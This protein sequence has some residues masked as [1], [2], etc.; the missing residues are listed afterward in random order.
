VLGF[1]LQNSI[2]LLPLQLLW[3][4]LMTD[5]LLGL[6]MGFEKAEKDVMCRPPRSPKEGIFSGG[7]AW[8][9]VGVGLFIGM[10][11]LGIGVGYYQANLPYWQSMLFTTAAFLQVFQALA[12]RSNIESIFSIG[13]FSNG[14]MWCIIGLVSL[15]QGLAL[16]TPLAT[17]LGLT[18]LPLFDFGLSIALG[19]SL[20]IVVEL[21]KVLLR[22]LKGRE[23]R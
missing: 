9:I 2:A 11:G 3:L 22:R 6:S 7:L 18:P 16:Y 1:P 12:T 5:G 14:W 8:Q 10:V 19:G 23:I 4:N 21:E 13:V 17:F 15:F 20:L